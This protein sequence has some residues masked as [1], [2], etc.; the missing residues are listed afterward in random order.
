MKRITIMMVALLAVTMVYAQK[1]KVSAAQAYIENGDL[2]AADT[3]I[4]D[5]MTHKKSVDWPK[6]YIVAAELARA[7]FKKQ[8]DPAL[9]NKAFD[10]YMKAIEL[11]KLDKGRFEK[12]IKVALTFFVNEMT[13]AGIEAFNAEKF[14]DAA[15][16]FENVLKINALD[17]FAG[18]AEGVDT[19]IVYNTALAAYNAQDWD[20]ATRYLKRSIE[21]NYGGG[22]AVL[23]L[24]QVY[25]NS[26]DSALMPI[27]LQ[28]GFI[29]YP[30]DDRILTQLINYYLE[31]KQNDRA[32]EYLDQAVEKDP[33]NS[34][35]YYARGVLNDQSKNF[36]SALNDYQKASEIDPEYFDAL[37]NMGVIY[38]NQG[39]EQMNVANEKTDFKE[40]EKEKA[41]SDSLFKESLP[42]M[43]RANKLK[44]EDA[45]VLESL[46]GLYYRFE[47]ND[48]YDKVKDKLDSMQGQ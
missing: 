43:E 18:E 21:L 46:K 32:L 26:G 37:Y 36:E 16:V 12:E 44:P 9:L 42:Y 2:D 28:Q 10:H 25:S 6:T 40:F 38:F 7:R 23:L 15:S 14:G 5:A 41:K 47:M 24:D 39:V 35:F 20:L 1:G 11:D 22:D 3:R 4:E 48:K 29:K 8:K 45:G 19:A 13:N 27:N 33:D 34:S 31:T 30:E 17:M